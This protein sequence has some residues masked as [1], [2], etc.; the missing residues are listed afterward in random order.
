[1]THALVTGIT[2][3]VDFDDAT[4]SNPLATS[5]YTPARG[6]SWEMPRDEILVP[7][8]SNDG[9]LLAYSRGTFDR[10]GFSEVLIQAPDAPSRKA[11][12]EAILDALDLARLYH[13]TGTGTPVDYVRGL[14]DDLDPDIFEVV[15][16][17]WGEPT[18]EL[19]ASK[20]RILQGTLT[21][22]CNR[23]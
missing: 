1:M 4:P 21:L 2:T 20:P 14:G 11:L 16:G 6:L 3:L 18:A 22:T 15:T 12:R 19:L 8:R 5:I 9:I 13:L 7:I 23:T 10:F 17:D